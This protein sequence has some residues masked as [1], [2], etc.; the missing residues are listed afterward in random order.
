MG[1]YIIFL[2]SDL[3]PC[4]NFIEKHYNNLKKNPKIVSIGYRKLL[5]NL[6]KNLLTTDIIQDNFLFI[7]NLPSKLDERIPFIYA[8]KKMN[9]DLTKAWYMAYSHNIAL[10]RSLYDK[11]EGFD[12]NFQ[13]G[14]GVED[15]EFALRLF[16]VG[17]RFYYDETITIYHIPHNSDSN[18]QSM[19]QTNL[20]YF[21]NK[22]KSCEAELFQLH[23]LMNPINLCKLYCTINSNSHLQNLDVK[24]YVNY[25]K[26]L[27]VG[28]RNFSEK[29]K[30]NGNNI[31]STQLSEAS[32]RLIGI[33][34]PYED[35]QFNQ[36]ILSQNYNLFQIELLYK[37]ITELI[38]VGTEVKICKDSKILIT[39][40]EF[41]KQKTSFT[42]KDWYEIFQKI[43]QRQ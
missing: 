42:F 7:E 23:H 13:F 10:R 3:I 27:F 21:Y 22:H 4:K 18:I 17:A 40:D 31:L 25:E 26:T 2:D 37:I 1:E 34:L 20:N 36:V 6:C 19:Y 28:F 16:K 24:E 38:R 12:E 15:V 14:W 35:K 39:L 11:T 41:W 5:L 33:F 32:Y 30:Q 8:H 29:L 9:L 43:E